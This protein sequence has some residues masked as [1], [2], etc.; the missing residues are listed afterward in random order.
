M[1]LTP[2]FRARST[3]VCH[4][5]SRVYERFSE[6]RLAVTVEMEV[7]G[8]DVRSVAFHRSL[9]RSD[10]RLT[11]GEVDE[12]NACLGAALAAGVR[13]LIEDHRP[14]ARHVRFESSLADLDERFVLRHPDVDLWVDAEGLRVV[15]RL[16]LARRRAASVHPARA[17]A[18]PVWR[19]E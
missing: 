12:L 19:F 18:S 7:E 11:Y 10:K 3:S 14:S 15:L 4:S 16:G 6:D 5:P 2:V 8:A 17:A 13:A 9:V 1:M